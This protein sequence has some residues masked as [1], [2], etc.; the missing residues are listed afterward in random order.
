M[1]YLPSERQK[2]IPLK[3]SEMADIF[4][5]K[6]SNGK[7]FLFDKTGKISTTEYDDFCYPVKRH[8]YADIRFAKILVTNNCSEEIKTDF[9]KIKSSNHP[10]IPF[11]KS[12]NWGYCDSK[13]NPVIPANYYETYEFNEGIGLIRKGLNFCFIDETGKECFSKDFDDAL[14][15]SEGFAAVKIGFK[16]G[17][18]DLKGNTVIEPKYDSCAYFTNG[19][20]KVGLNGRFGFIDKSGKLVIDCQFDDCNCFCN[21]LAPFKDFGRW[22]YVDKSGNVKIE[23][24]FDEAGLFYNGYA[25]IKLNGKYGFID[26][27]GNY[28]YE[29]IFEAAYDIFSNFTYVKDG[30]EWKLITT[31]K[32]ADEPDNLFYNT[33]PNPMQPYLP[34][35]ESIPIIEPAAEL[36]TMDETVSEKPKILNNENIDLQTDILKEI[37]TDE[38]N[39]EY[40][41]LNDERISS[42][43]DLDNI[44]ND[45]DYDVN[46]NE[47]EIPT[48]IDLNDEDS[49]PN[50][51]QYEN[52]NIH[53]NEFRDANKWGFSDDA[54]NIVIEP[55]FEDAKKFSDGLAAVKSQ[56]LW[57][58]IDINAEFVIEP[59][60]VFANNFSDGFALVSEDN[61]VCYFINKSGNRAFD[62]TFDYAT[63]FKKGYAFVHVNHQP[64]YIDKKGDLHRKMETNSSATGSS[65]INSKPSTKKFIWALFLIGIGIFALVSIFNKKHKTSTFDW[66]GMYAAKQEKF[67]QIKLLANDIAKS[68]FINMFSAADKFTATLNY[69]YTF[70]RQATYNLLIDS[71]DTYVKQPNIVNCIIVKSAAYADDYDYPYYILKN[72]PKLSYAFSELKSNKQKLPDINIYERVGNDSIPLPS[73]LIAYNNKVIPI[74]SCFSDRN[75]VDSN[76]VKY[77]NNAAEDLRSLSNSNYTVDLKK[78]RSENRMNTVNALDSLLRIRLYNPQADEYRS[79]PKNKGKIDRTG[80]IDVTY[81]FNAYIVPEWASS[82]FYFLNKTKRVNSARTVFFAQDIDK[83][84]LKTYDK[85]TTYYGLVLS[86]KK[87]MKFSSVFDLVKDNLAIIEKDR[88]ESYY[89]NSYFNYSDEYILYFKDKQ[90][91][92]EIK[93]LIEAI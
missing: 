84:T 80:L 74:S 9:S 40:S 42:E 61:Q 15:F 31:E 91:A 79:L 90:E 20:A 33:M 30:A 49:L 66:D 37:P 82:T 41:I 69:Y 78:L 64:Y 70:Q 10:L 47:S 63:D 36:I 81:N 58:Y 18:I 65:A 85:E 39:K 25:G 54:G 2:L 76:I 77:V 12:I 28:L 57:G 21:G 48:D 13:A 55:Q 26:R 89:L 32:K 53:L 3:S 56:D 14:Q 27:D 11:N 38:I 92:L 62:Y 60:F 52:N 46:E 59:N 35:E 34:E 29:P 7:V 22:G 19:L 50:N 88:L 93:K 51:Q 6:G 5:I 75:W 67:P 86:L 8:N 1:F 45:D 71:I 24:K 83:I 68:S 87:D 17:F 44:F 72:H 16:F 4:P 23:A 73:V 43:E